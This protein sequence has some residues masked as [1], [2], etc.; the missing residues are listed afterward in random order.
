L[1]PLSIATCQ[2]Y[3]SDC[4]TCESRNLAYSGFTSTS[5]V[6]C[7]RYCPCFQSHKHTKLTCLRS[8]VEVT[9]QASIALELFTKH[10]T[11]LQIFMYV[12]ITPVVLR[13]KVLSCSRFFSHKI[14][15]LFA[16][17]GKYPLI[18]N[19]FLREFT[20]I[21]CFNLTKTYLAENVLYLVCIF[22]CHGLLW[23]GLFVF[24]QW[25]V[26]WFTLIFYS[27]G[28]LIMVPNMVKALIMHCNVASYGFAMI[29][30]SEFFEWGFVSYW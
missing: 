24:L 28:V 3:K 6:T 18:P 7:S 2:W 1:P 21:L 16:S 14:V 15:L 22:A 11:M 4:S 5:Y 8:K 30:I 12:D 19:L 29:T 10:C 20:E 25:F 27:S 9:E 23:V 26:D 13:E 17:V